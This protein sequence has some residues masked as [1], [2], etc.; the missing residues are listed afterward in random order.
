[1][2]MYTE[3]NIGVNLSQ[4]TPTEVIETIQRMLC[5]DDAY[6]PSIEHP[7]F[8]TERYHWMLNM[9]SYYFDGFTNSAIR[10]DHVS[11]E[12][13]LDIRCN[14]KNYSHE[15]ELFLDFIAPYITTS[16]FLGYIRYEADELPT[17]IFRGCNK[18]IFTK[19]EALSE[20]TLADVLG[21]NK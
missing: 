5:S 6:K 12:W 14:L 17:L 21:K 15:I 19:P 4:T 10:Q 9:D 1:M 18:I 16:G 7:L 2:G 20:Q 11:K 13:Q 3:L 8:K